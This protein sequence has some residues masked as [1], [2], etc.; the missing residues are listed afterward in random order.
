MT[1]EQAPRGAVLH[2]PGL[3][4]QV[5]RHRVQEDP[6][7]EPRDGILQQGELF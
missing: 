1:T 2:R 4:G 5:R 3:R 6:R 7:K